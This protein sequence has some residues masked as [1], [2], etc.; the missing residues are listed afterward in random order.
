MP[1]SKNGYGMIKQTRFFCIQIRC[2]MTNLCLKDRGGRWVENI[3]RPCFVFFSPKVKDTLR[4]L[5]KCL[6]VFTIISRNDSTKL[7]FLQLFID[8]LSVAVG[9]GV[10]DPALLRGPE[11]A[12]TRRRPRGSRVPQNPSPDPWAPQAMPLPGPAGRAY[13]GSSR[14]RPSAWD[15]TSGY[16][17][18]LGFGF[19]GG[20]RLLAVNL[21]AHLREKKESQ[22]GRPTRTRSSP[23]CVARRG[24]LRPGHPG[25]S[26]RADKAGYPSP[27]S[28]AGKRPAQPRP[29]ESHDH[30]LFSHWGSPPPASGPIGAEPLDRG[31]GSGAPALRGPWCFGAER[32]RTLFRDP[33]RYY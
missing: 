29:R 19:P 24:Q 12:P 17:R 30:P 21:R 9:W 4:S 25:D 31:R 33:F 22:P 26:L 32:S 27:F 5:E 1:V 28:L 15:G 16:S 13:Q 14:R 7:L 8:L 6:A 20:R 11:A 23:L 10:P 2:N 18:T 3:Q